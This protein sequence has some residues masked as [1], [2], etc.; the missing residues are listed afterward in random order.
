MFDKSETKKDL[1]FA[2]NEAVSEVELRLTWADC[3]YLY[4][5]GKFSGVSETTFREKGDAHK[6][7]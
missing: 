2:C 7:T 6:K 1:C 4:H 5:L 3:E